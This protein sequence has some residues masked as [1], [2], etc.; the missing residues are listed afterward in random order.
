VISCF[1]RKHSPAVQELDT[2]EE[3]V[4]HCLKKWGHIVFK[5]PEELLK[6]IQGVKK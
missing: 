2:S 4:S 6:M 3:D 5:K 1:G